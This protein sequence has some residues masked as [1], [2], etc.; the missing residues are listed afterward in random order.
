V[1][2]SHPNELIKESQSLV[3]VFSSIRGTVT[4]DEPLSSQE[5]F[6]YWVRSRF[7]QRC[8]PVESAA[9][10]LFLNK[11][12]FRG[13]YREG[14][15][16]FNVPFGNY[17]NPGILD[18]DHI[19]EVSQLIQR[20]TFTTR[21]YKESLAQVRPGDFVYLDPPYA[22]E[23]ETSFVSYTKGGFNE[24]EALFDACK[25][26]P[27]AFLMSNSNVKLV[28]DAFRGHRVHEVTARRAINSKKPDSKTTEVVIECPSPT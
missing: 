24:H 16:G 9:M 6:Y 14:P 27:C 1:V 19:H 10:F 22:P 5:A 3:G 20:V 11:T 13:V 28:R 18:E 21:D 25:H 7:N 8:T 26:L 15:R 23:T 12:C 4:T 2:Q 17:K